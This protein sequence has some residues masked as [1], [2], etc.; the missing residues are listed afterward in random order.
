MNIYLAKTT[1][2]DSPGE[3]IYVIRA[4][5]L[6]DAQKIM[7]AALAEADDGVERLALITTVPPGDIVQVD[8]DLV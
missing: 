8:M 2:T 5:S 7:K 1:Y 3:N 4:A 6:K